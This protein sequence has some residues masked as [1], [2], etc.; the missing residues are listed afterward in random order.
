MVACVVA[1]DG[2]IVDVFDR[3]YPLDKKDVQGNYECTASY[4]N[5]G[6]FRKPKRVGEV[7][8]Y[9]VE[10]YGKA[11]VEEVFIPKFQEMLQVTPF[12]LDRSAFMGLVLPV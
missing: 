12:E 9:L 8:P 4:A 1:E 10:T 6:A 2:S 3:D 7:Y 11:A 5:R